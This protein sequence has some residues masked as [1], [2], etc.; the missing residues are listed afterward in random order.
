MCDFEEVIAKKHQNEK[1]SHFTNFWKNL[2]CT[3]IQKGSRPN[4]VAFGSPYSNL[5]SPKEKRMKVIF[6]WEW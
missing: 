4:C 2:Y 3:T 1:F 6:K 5:Q